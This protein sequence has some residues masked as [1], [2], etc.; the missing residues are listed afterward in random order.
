MSTT[1]SPESRPP[2]P[3]FSLEDAIK[4]VRLAENAWNTRDPHKVTRN[5]HQNM[6]VN[7]TPIVISPM[8]V[9]S[10]KDGVHS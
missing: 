5:I 9:H 2:V 7:N 3:P 10:G 4:K 8:Y 1:S 6:I